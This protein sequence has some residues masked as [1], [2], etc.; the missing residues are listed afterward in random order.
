M[1]RSV[2]EISYM[3]LKLKESGDEVASG[4]AVNNFARFITMLIIFI[5]ILV[6][7][8]YTTRF[9]AG[10]KKGSFKSGNMEVLECLQLGGGKCLQLLRLGKRYVVVAVT[11]DNVEMLAELDEDEYIKSVESSGGSFKEILLSKLKNGFGA[12]GDKDNK[13]GSDE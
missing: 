7:T 8:Y 1:S 3:L 12:F 9:V 11:K 13:E 4:N 5:L 6:L 2:N 10:A